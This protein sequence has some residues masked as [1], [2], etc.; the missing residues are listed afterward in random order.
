MKPTR[1]RSTVMAMAPSWML[2]E[3]SSVV[4]SASAASDATTSGDKRV[5]ATS[6]PPNSSA[7]Y[8]SVAGD[9][10]TCS[11]IPAG[12]TATAPVMPAINPNFELASTSS[13]SD[14]TVDGTIADFDT[15]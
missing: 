10:T 5:A 13:D 2:D 1:P 11:R 9:P 14:R 4:S 3:C 8:T 15:A 7:P 6:A 12:I